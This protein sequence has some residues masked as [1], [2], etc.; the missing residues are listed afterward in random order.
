MTSRVLPLLGWVWLRRWWAWYGVVR[1]SRLVVLPRA[2][3]LSRSQRACRRPFGW[4]VGAA[5]SWR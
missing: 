2:V 4:C 5:G 1:L 3:R